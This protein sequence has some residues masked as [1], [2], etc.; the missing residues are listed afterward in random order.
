MKLAHIIHKQFSV[1][2]FIKGVD[3]N[4]SSFNQR[5]IPRNY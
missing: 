5:S 3:R 2:D 1:Y 4:E